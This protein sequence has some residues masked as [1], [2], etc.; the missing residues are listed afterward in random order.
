MSGSFEYNDATR[1]IRI[2]GRITTP[3]LTLTAHKDVLLL[4]W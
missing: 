3:E 4:G 1:Q 2:D